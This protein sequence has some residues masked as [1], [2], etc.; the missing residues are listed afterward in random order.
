MES[1]PVAVFGRAM[2]R[3][4]RRRRRRE[5]S[6]QRFADMPLIEADSTQWFGPGK[7][8]DA[9]PLTKTPEQ[10]KTLREAVKVWAR[11]RFSK[12]MTAMNV[13]TGWGAGDTERHHQDA[14][15]WV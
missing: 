14:F 8:I 3:C 12:G 4:T 6:R 1:R 13:D 10:A 7:A 15:P 11:E 2:R 9:A 5:P